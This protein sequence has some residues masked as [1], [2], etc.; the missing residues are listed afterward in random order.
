MP[1]PICLNKQRLTVASLKTSRRQ[2]KKKK[3]IQLKYKH[4]C[5]NVHNPQS[6][7]L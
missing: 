5:I 7:A 2:E 6:A 3:K 1:E 4:K